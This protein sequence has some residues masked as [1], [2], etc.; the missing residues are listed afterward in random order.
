MHSSDIS[1]LILRDYAIYDKLSWLCQI[2]AKWYGN[3][4][5]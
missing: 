4:L 5:L 2:I 1:K 3:I